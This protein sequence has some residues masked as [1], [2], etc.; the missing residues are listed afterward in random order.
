MYAMK[1]QPVLY[2]QLTEILRQAITGYQLKNG[3]VT[4]QITINKQYSAALLFAYFKRERER[5]K[6]QLQ[7][8]EM[9]FG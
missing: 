9:L 1:L 7:K 6:A 4:S 3:T 8:L 2:M 5:E